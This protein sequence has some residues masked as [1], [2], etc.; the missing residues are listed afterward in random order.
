MTATPMPLRSSQAISSA[1]PSGVLGA[2]RRSPSPRIQASTF[3][4]ATSRP[5][6]PTFCA[7]LRLPSLLVRALTPLQLFGLK[8]DTGPV[9]RS[10]AGSCL[11]WD[12][13]A[14]IQR[15]AVG[16]TTARSHT[17]PDFSDTRW[18]GKADTGER[19]DATALTARDQNIRHIACP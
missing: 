16:R 8:E 4:L 18:G 10:P 17:L 14:Q 2:D 11:W 1:S 7:I 3:F 12:L 5:T 13:R 15:R 19:A 9:P 6:T